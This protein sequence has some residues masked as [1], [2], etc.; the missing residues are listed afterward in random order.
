MPVKIR[1]SVTDASGQQDVLLYLDEKDTT[2]ATQRDG[3]AYF[4]Y[5]IPSSSVSAD[6][7]VSAH[8]T[9]QTYTQRSV[10]M[11][12]ASVC[13]G[14]KQSGSNAEFFVSAQCFSL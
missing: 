10:H 6:F 4:T 8:V 13:D 1:G 7:F 9:K 3:V 14:E 12:S 5:N 11:F 2:Q